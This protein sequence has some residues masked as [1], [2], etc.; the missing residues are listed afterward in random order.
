MSRSGSPAETALAGQGRQRHGDVSPAYLRGPITTIN[1]SGQIWGTSQR[2]V[3]KDGHH[4]NINTL[5]ENQ[6]EFKARCTKKENKKKP[7][8]YGIYRYKAEAEMIGRGPACTPRIQ[9]E[10]SNQADRSVHNVSHSHCPDCP[11]RWDRLSDI[12]ACCSVP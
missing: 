3:T 9:D 5:P 8:I 6:K 1:R 12:C 4:A 11:R 10:A 7:Y 2:L